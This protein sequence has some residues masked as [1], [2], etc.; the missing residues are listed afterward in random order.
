MYKKIRIYGEEAGLHFLVDV[1]TLKSEEYLVEK[2]K[3]Y[4]VRVYGLSEYFLSSCKYKS[5]KT[6]VF[7]YSNL[8]FSSLR[9]GVEVLEVAWENI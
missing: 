7:G 8:D 4:G 9:N 1:D 3:K 5:K 6:I 2:A